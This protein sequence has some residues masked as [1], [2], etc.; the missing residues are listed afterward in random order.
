M[1]EALLM[2]HPAAI[3]LILL[4]LG[5]VPAAAQSGRV[6]G[7]VIDETGAVLP[8]ATVTLTGPGGA[9]ATPS[10]G[11]GEYAFAGLVAGTYTVTV[12]LS[13]F[14]DA[15]VEGVVVTDAPLELPPVI[16]SL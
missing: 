15:A 11:S 13:G 16:L 7:S 3:G 5:A 12:A 2:R 4:T 8:G 10:D 14:S 6:A 9:R 1:E